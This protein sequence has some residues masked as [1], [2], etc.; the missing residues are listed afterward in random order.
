MRFQL[1]LQCVWDADDV[2]DLPEPEILKLIEDYYSGLI[3][4]DLDRGVVKVYLK[5]TA[6][7]LR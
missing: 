6:R 1:D 3:S 2:Q 4:D 7:V 5:S